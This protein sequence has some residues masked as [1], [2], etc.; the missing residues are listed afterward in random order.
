MADPDTLIRRA[1]FDLIGL[2][3]TPEEIQVFRAAWE[4]DS[5][6]A[7]NDLIN[8][9]LA[10]PHY[11]ER[12]GQHWL[13]VARYAD[14]AGYSNDYERSNMWRYRD[15]VVR[16]FNEDKPYN[17]FIVEQIA[18]DEL[19][20]E[21]SGPNKNP[22]LLVATSFLRMGPWDPAMVKNPEARQMYLDDVVNSVGQ[23]FLSTTLRCCKCHDHKFDPIPTRDYYRLYAAFATTQLAERP[24]PFLPEENLEGFDNGQA[25]VQRL[26]N[27]AIQRKQ[28]LI[29]K[30]ET[31]ARKWYAE[32]DLEYVNYNQRKSLPDDMKPPRHVG[33]D[34]VDQGRLKVREQDE[35]IW[36]RRLER[37]QPMVQSV[38]NG[39]D[40]K[41]LNA[42]KL[43]MPEKIKSDVQMVSFVYTGGSLEAPGEQVQPGVMSATGVP[44]GEFPE[45]PYVIDADI[46]G[47]RLAV[48]HWIADP[49]IH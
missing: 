15:Y 30:R 5:E 19:W 13:D 21:Q 42:R 26:L 31:A 4:Q 6:R 24:A 33:L 10:S 38:Y 49:A 11:G 22:E 43:R 17:E 1:T 25:L 27:F 16:A 32:H 41:F 12:W 2:P 23:T 34:P 28:Q 48:A 9:L 46:S 37:Y 47:R 20:E 45:D 44:I 7:W 14:T 29:Q 36:N 39:P 3:P 18:G 35:W 40:P 8:R